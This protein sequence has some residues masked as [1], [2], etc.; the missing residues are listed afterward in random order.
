[1]PQKTT[2]DRRLELDKK[3]K[4]LPGV[5]VYFQPPASI[6]MSYPAIR[7]Q[8]LTIGTRHA[9]DLPYLRVPVYRVTVIDKD[10]DSPIAEAV[11]AFPGCRFDNFFT[12][13]NLNH[14]V[15]ELYL[16]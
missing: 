11:S 3:F 6:R 8:L 4:E 1:M 2:K 5:H 10:P 14:F 7:Y 9:D 13:D 16:T 15:F 12:A